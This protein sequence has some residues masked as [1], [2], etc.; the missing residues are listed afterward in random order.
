[1]E[2]TWPLTHLRRWAATPDTITFDFGTHEQDYIV[3][4]TEEGEAI[5]Q[6]IGGYIDILIKRQ[7]GILTAAHFLT[8]LERNV[9]IE[10]K[11]EQGEVAEV[12][13]VAKLQAVVSTA[14]TITV[15][16]PDFGL[17][18]VIDVDS[19]TRA[20]NK[21]MQYVTSTVVAPAAKSALTE[22]QRR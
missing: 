4:L 15:T 16:G 12:S 17:K 11:E 1:M 8:K 19:A 18:G 9:I 10:A 20:V 5:S 21:M 13:E 14:N 22:E 3:F 6:L 7:Q 2:K